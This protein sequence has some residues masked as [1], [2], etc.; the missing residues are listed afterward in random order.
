[1]KSKPMGFNQTIIRN[2]RVRYI[3]IAAAFL[4]AAMSVYLLFNG[5][6]DAAFFSAVLS[7]C[8]FFLSI[9]FQIKERM[10]LRITSLPKQDVENIANNSKNPTM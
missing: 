3:L 10:R 9:R 6:E 4:L 5:M 2:L 1:M 7:A 8:F